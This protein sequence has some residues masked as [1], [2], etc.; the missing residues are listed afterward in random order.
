MQEPRLPP[1]AFLE[2]A[3][4]RGIAF[5]DGD[6]DRLGRFLAAL[7]EANRSFNLTGITDPEVAWERHILD[8]LE[9]L[10]LIGDLG[11]DTVVDI[12]SGG[13]LPGLPLA[14]VLPQVRFTLLEATGK[15]AR[16]L[17]QV[18]RD[19][20]LANVRVVHDRAELAAAPAGPLRD[21]FDVATA[22]GVG[23]LAVL[24]ELAIPLLRE[25]GTL[26]AIKGER[27]AEEASA[28]RGAM[29]ALRTEL[30]GTHRTPTSTIVV[31]RKI[32]PTPRRFPRRPGEPSN[33]P[34]A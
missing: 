25:G 19:L 33:H 21:R 7:L 30:L 5:D 4:E 15:K 32:G 3:R 34:I 6:L 16:F 29:R 12:G 18:T 8:S 26:L 27:A 14:V 2:R 28:A 22:R 23:A 1:A 20:G 17:E 31:L 24:V 9:L 10:P 13:G 11:P